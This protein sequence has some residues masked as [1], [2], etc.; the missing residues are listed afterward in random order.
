MR[1]AIFNPY[2]DTLGG[3]ERYSMAVAQALLLKGY[4]VNLEWKDPSIKKEY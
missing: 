3:G 2:L 4:T 1:A